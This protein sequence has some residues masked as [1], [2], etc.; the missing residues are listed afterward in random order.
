MRVCFII[1]LFSTIFCACRENSNNG[2]DSAY[3]Q[4]ELTVYNQLLDV[5]LDS[6]GY[7]VVDTVRQV[8]YLIDTLD[9]VEYAGDNDFINSKFKKRTFSIPE[10]TEK[11]QHKYIKATDNITN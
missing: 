9:N 1:I 3:Q 10:L 4:E 11:S 5:L 6:A 8:F 2:D 7:E